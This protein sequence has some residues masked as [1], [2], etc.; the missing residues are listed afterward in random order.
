MSKV[1]EQASLMGKQ[2]ITSR[3]MSKRCSKR[4]CGREDILGEQGG[5]RR[6]EM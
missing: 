6:L 2:G 1:E 5:I 3:V 4:K